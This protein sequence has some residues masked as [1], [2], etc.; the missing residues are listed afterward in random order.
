MEAPEIW[1]ALQEV[2]DPELGVNVVDLGLVYEVDVGPGAVEVVLTM[3]SPACPMVAQL[4]RDAEAAVR[5]A[6]PA[7]IALFTLQTA[8]SLRRAR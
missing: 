8:V 4:A 5:R 2:L 7:A 6:A 3:T 1:R